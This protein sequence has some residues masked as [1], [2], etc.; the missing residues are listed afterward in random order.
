VADVLAR[1][2]SALTPVVAEL[3]RLDAAGLLTK[4]LP[5]LFDSYLHMHCNRILND[6]P[7][8]RRVLGLLL[9]TRET[10][11]RHPEGA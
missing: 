7:S 10:L 6:Q 4:P 2:K 11:A 9:R 5:E 3:A 8:E 1:R